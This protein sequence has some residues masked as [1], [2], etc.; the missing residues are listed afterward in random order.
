MNDYQKGYNA[1]QDGEE[2]NF[3]RSSDWLCGW[4]AAEADMSKQ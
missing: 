3:S 1:R 2:V 4:Y